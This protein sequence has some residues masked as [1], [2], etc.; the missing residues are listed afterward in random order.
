MLGAVAA[1]LVVAAIVLLL[2]PWSGSPSASSRSGSS[3]DH[4]IAE[5]VNLT[6]SDFPSGWTADSSTGPLGGFLGSSGQRADPGLTPAQ[7]RRAT[8]I[9]RTFQQ[10]VGVPASKDGVFES[11]GSAPSARVSSPGFAGPPSGL[12]MEA[13]SRVSVFSSS[14]PVTVAVAEITNPKFPR[15]FGAVIGKELTL[16][17][18]RVATSSPGVSYGAP[19]VQPLTLPQHAG[20]TAVGVDVT[21]PLTA[22]NLSGSLQFDLVLVGGG[23]IEAV[24]VAYGLAVGGSSG[25]PTSLTTSLTTTL[26]HNVATEGAATGA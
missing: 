22:G 2:A 1:A 20:A 8:R 17:A 15:C 26:E 3:D 10:C 16:V 18:Q 19:Q 23:R 9:I 5:Q 21:L 7:R 12:A 11:A 4:E 24:L 25:F 14:G 6:R 13:G